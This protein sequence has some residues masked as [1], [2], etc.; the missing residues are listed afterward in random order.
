M[1]SNLGKFQWNCI[2]LVGFDALGGVLQPSS[3]TIPNG[4]VYY[5]P[6]STE[7]SNNQ[8]VNNG[9]LITGDLES[10]LASL[11]ENLSISKTQTVK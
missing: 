3:Q 10:S 8:Q 4:N 5:Y 9:A 11:A 2:T 7:N 1:S 6:A